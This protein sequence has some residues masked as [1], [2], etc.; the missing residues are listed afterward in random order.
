VSYRAADHPIASPAAA[1]HFYLWQTTADAAAMNHTITQQRF[2]LGGNPKAPRGSTPD[3]KQRLD[4]R[5]REAKLIRK[6][7]YRGSTPSGIWT[8]PHAV[9][10]RDPFTT[11]CGAP[12]L[13]GCEVPS[14][15]EGWPD[16]YFETRW[17]EL[18]DPRAK[19]L[20]CAGAIG[21][22]PTV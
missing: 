7:H 11:A 6:R 14:I 21:A 20:G 16:G 10:L 15:W 9:S 4:D 3:V 12:Y 18:L 5:R 22:D 13:G 2:L 8:L 1:V 17:F 19:C